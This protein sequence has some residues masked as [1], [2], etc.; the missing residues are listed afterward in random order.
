MRTLALL[1]FVLLLATHGLVACSPK[2]PINA[3]RRPITE[4]QK[5]LGHPAIGV[6]TFARTATDEGACTATLVGNR[7]VITAAHCL[8]YPKQVFTLAATASE[9]ER[10]FPAREVI[11]HPDFKPKVPWN[12]DIGV[13][14][15]TQA[16]PIESL[17]LNPLPPGVGEAITLIGFGETEKGAKDNG[18]KRIATNEISAV[19]S[20]FFEVSGSKGTYGNAC[21]GDSG[22]ATLATDTA[23]NESIIGLLSYINGA[24]GESNTF[25]TR[26]DIHLPWLRKV[27]KGDLH[28]VGETPPAS[29]GLASGDAGAWG[30]GQHPGGDSEGGCAITPLPSAGAALIGLLLAAFVWGSRRA[31]S[32]S[33]SAST[34]KEKK[35]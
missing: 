25:V 27:T 4:G 29:D 20:L 22:G 12:N 6:L 21:Y 1:L 35:G 26:V 10:R 16:P 14:L 19:R 7:V 9:P 11:Y 33:P 2:A 13:V 28:V 5:H 23:G 17:R 24:C 31:T 3:L 34:H 32:A 30:D 8:V 18:V 15:L